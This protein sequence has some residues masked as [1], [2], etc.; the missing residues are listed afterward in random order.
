M[1]I[2]HHAALDHDVLARHSHAPPVPIT[3]GLDGD[4]IVAG[5]ELA[6]LNQNVG[7]ALRIAPVIV[8]TV[9]RD[10]HIA[11][12]YVPAQHRMDLI[13]RRIPD[14]HP[15]NQYAVAAIRLNKLRPQIRALAETPLLDGNI[16]LAHLHQTRT[17]L[18]LARIALFPSAVGAS[19]PGPP[20]FTVGLPVDY[21][22][23]RNRD[24]FLTMSVNER[25]VV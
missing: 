2:L 6:A 21:A 25:G 24:V 19:F 20:V 22:A 23:P 3:S 13:H 8:G 7:A 17:R 10:L 14:G 1:P 15:I 5:I 18:R 11:H 12:R 4:T 9:T 16:G